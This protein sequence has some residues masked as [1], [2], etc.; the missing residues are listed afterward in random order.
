MAGVRTGP[1]LPTAAPMLTAR[2]VG[3][4]LGFEP[5]TVLGWARSGKLPSHKIERAVRFDRAEIEAWLGERQRATPTRGVLATPN[6]AAQR[7]GYP[8]LATPHH[9]EE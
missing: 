3:E 4:W 5:A 2:E 1:R 8:V 7:L 6:G 9:E